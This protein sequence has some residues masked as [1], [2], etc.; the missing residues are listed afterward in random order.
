M[1]TNTSLCGPAM[2][3]MGL[4]GR[5]TINIQG[6]IEISY[7]LFQMTFHTS[8]DTSSRAPIFY[9]CMQDPCHIHLPCVH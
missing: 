6:N 8:R 9:I 2:K 4:E 1:T 7:D 3:R 5:N